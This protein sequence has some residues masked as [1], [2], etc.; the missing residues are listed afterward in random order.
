MIRRHPRARRLTLRLPLGGDGVV[1]TLPERAA[2]ADG[3]ALARTN[4]GWIA[5]RMASR[6][7]RVCFCNGAILPLRGAGHEIRHLPAGSAG[8][9]VR[10]TSAS[11]SR[12][13][14]S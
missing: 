2:F 5:E 7:E 8:P 14:G 1:V 6:P 4:S 10:S 3:I 12:T 13:G 11:P 9:H